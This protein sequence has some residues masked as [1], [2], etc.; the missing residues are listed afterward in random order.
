MP[1]GKPPD[2]PCVK[3][4]WGP[5]W[6]PSRQSDDPRGGGVDPAHRRGRS[7]RC[8]GSAAGYPPPADYRPL[9][10]LPVGRPERTPEDPLLSFPGG[11]FEQDGSF[12]AESPAPRLPW[13]HLLANP[14]LRHSGF[15]RLS[16]LHLGSERPGK[17]PDSLG[18]RH[19][20][21]QPRG[22]AADA[23]GRSKRGGG[24]DPGSQG[25]LW[26]G[27]ARYDGA[28]GPLRTRVT[29]SVPEK[30]S[31]KLVEI[32]IEN[33]GKEEAEIQLAYYTEPVLGVNRDNARHLTA[34]WENGALLMSSPFSPVA[35]SLILTAFGG[36]EG[37]DCDRGAFLSGKWGSGTLAPL[38]DPC[39]AVIVK[40]QLPP[41][42]REKVTFVLGF[43]ARDP[44]A[45]R[46][47]GLAEADALPAPKAGAAPRLSTPDAALNAVF[48]FLL[49]QVK[50][51]R[52]FGRTG[53]Y[54]SGGAWGFRDQLQDA[55]AMLWTEPVLLRRQLQRCAAAQFEEGDV[56]HWW[57]RLPG[58]GLHGVRTRCSDDLVWLPYALCEYTAFTGDEAVWDV[59]V[60]FLTAE[61]LR[62]EEDDRYFEPAVSDCREPLY[63]HGARALDRALT[64]G[65]HGCPSSEAATGTTASACW[66]SRAGV[67]VSG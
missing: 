29:L 30:G 50:R 3:A 49:E 15:R 67:K 21:G 54:Q 57:H 36:A 28:A 12:T 60:P 20:F 40:K 31:V 44:A 37:C 16:G 47:A 39:A 46:L 6:H 18:Q 64:A 22:A 63:E 24:S 32:E 53:F 23:A 26:P 1:S 27:Y 34:R 62:E 25:A 11:R 61:P 38:P 51:C 7:Q 8:P 56:L 4:C 59:P 9:P 52:L 19:R 14:G 43:A 48:P 65:E 13:C 35:G 17:P 45:V 58:K 33:S 66:A 5:G 42:R 2:P 10:I 55:L 41:K